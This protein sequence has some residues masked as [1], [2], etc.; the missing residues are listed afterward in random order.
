MSDL[1]IT[2]THLPSHP[3]D[4]TR[5]RFAPDDPCNSVRRAVSPQLRKNPQIKRSS[6]LPSLLSGLRGDLT[7]AKWAQDVD[8]LRQIAAKIADAESLQSLGEIFIRRLHSSLRSFNKTLPSGLRTQP[9]FVPAFQATIYF[10]VAFSGQ[11]QRLQKPAPKDDPVDVWQVSLVYLELI[12]TYL[13]RLAEIIKQSDPSPM[14]LDPNHKPLPQVPIG[15]T[16]PPDGIIFENSST[17]TT[18][19]PAASTDS[20]YIV[21]PNVLEQPVPPITSR[22]S[23][24]SLRRL[25]PRIRKKPTM[26]LTIPTYAISSESTTTLQLS[27]HSEMFHY[28]TDSGGSQSSDT[29][30][31]EG[32]HS[33]PPEDKLEVTH[34]QTTEDTYYSQGGVLCAAKIAALLRILTSKEAVIDPTFQ[35]V[36]FLSFRFFS[37]PAEVFENLVNR[38]NEEPPQNLTEAQTV[39]WAGNAVT[40][41]IRVAK[42]FL[43]WLKIHWCSKRDD[44]IIEPLRKFASERSAGDPALAIW[45]QVLGILVDASKCDVYNDDRIQRSL[46]QSV[47]AA[48]ARRSHTF[49]LLTQNDVLRGNYDSVDILHFHSV[50][51]R[52]EL[53]CQLSIAASRFYRNFDPEDAVQFWANRLDK[54][55]GKKI[56]KLTLFENALVY[57]TADAILAKPTVRSRAE[58]MEFFVDLASVS[59]LTLYMIPIIGAKDMTGMPQVEEFCVCLFDNIRRQLVHEPTARDY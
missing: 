15:S 41:K 18:E 10:G 5:V 35:N 23:K 40:T 38:Y 52:E 58:T 44:E 34:P 27:P 21:H 57:W 32:S 55:V 13:K 45:G 49:M 17:S 14:A 4:K 8:R 51:G 56:K 25:M 43:T 46:Q 12:M 9:E 2:L 36:F 11:V 6:S 39:T 59:V 54:D 26:P 50:A 1:K 20:Y 30:F 53:A 16:I 48:D 3:V 28:A 47:P 19:P 22:P 42:V 33:S 29:L 7:S 24:G 31:S 37:S